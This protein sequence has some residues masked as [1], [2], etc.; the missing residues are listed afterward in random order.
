L[1]TLTYGHFFSI[2]SAAEISEGKIPAELIALRRQSMIDRY[3][4]RQCLGICFRSAFYREKCSRLLQTAGILSGARLEEWERKSHV[5]YP[6]IPAV[7]KPRLSMDEQLR[8]LFMG[9]SGD[10]GGRVATAVFRRIFAKFGSA[11]EL[12]YVGSTDPQEM[13][14]HPYIY[15]Y[16]ELSRESYFALLQKSQIFFS[17]TAY[18]SFGMGLVE[19]AC[20]GLAILTTNGP[21]MEHIGE[22]LTQDRNALFVS[23]LLP[24]DRQIAEFDLLMSTLIGRRELISYMSHN[25]LVSARSGVLSAGTRKEELL[26]LYTS[27]PPAAARQQDL[28]IRSD[29]PPF[30]THRVSSQSC[31]T[32][33]MRLTQGNLRLVVP[34]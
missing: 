9:R 29:R 24:A 8:I 12:H 6:T 16:P 2:G 17:P 25:N 5:L 33:F 23:N 26:R 31:E 4:D 34:V 11:V 30:E 27:R 19:A 18:E 10:K 3:L 20:H 14:D 22:I 13:S 28:S 15:Y 7:E 1:A 21:G 32:E